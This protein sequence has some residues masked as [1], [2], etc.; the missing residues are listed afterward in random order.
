MMNRMKTYIFFKNIWTGVL[1]I[2]SEILAVLIFIAAGF[3]V[4]LAWWSLLK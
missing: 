3:I 4:S 2:A 1:G